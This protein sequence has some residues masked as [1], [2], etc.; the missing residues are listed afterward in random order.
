[1]LKF[2]LW[3]GSKDTAAFNTHLEVVEYLTMGTA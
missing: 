2:Y 1:M 3:V